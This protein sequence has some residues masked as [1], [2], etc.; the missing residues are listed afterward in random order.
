MDKMNWYSTEEKQNNPYWELN[1][2]PKVATSKRVIANVKL[3]YQIFEN[4]RFEIR[5]NIDY[6]DM[7]RDYRYA[8]D[9]NSVSVSS[10]GSWAY[11]KYTDQSVYTDGILTY[12]KNFGNF[13]LNALA[14][15]SYKKNIFNDGMNVSNGPTNPLQYPNFFTFANIP[16]NV[17][18]NQTINRTIKQ[19]GFVNATVGFKNFLFLDLAGRNDWASTLALTGNQSYF[20]PSVGASAIVSE[21]IKLPEVISF[22]KLRASFTQT[23]NEVPFNTVNPWNSIGGTG[24]VQTGVGTINYNTQQPFDN[25]KPEKIVANEYG[26]E[27]RFLNNR[28]GFDFT[29]YKDVS[30]NQFLT[31][32]APSGTAYTFYYVNAGKIVNRGFEFTVNIEPIRNTHFT[33]NTAFN[34]S[35]NKNKIVELISSDP[36]YQV[37]GDDEGF[38]SIIKA[39]GSFNDV[40][41]FKFARN[42]AGQIILAEGAQTSPAPTKTASQEY[43]GNVNPDFILGWNNNFT[44]NNFFA[45]ILVNGKFGGI[46]F[47]K[48]EA[49]LDS[50]GVSER[51]A[52]ARDLGYVPINAVLGATPVT[53]IDPATYYSTIGDRN[54]IMEPYIYSRT[55]VR[56]AQLVLGYTFRSKNPNP[57]FKDASVSLVGR[58]LFFLY[59]K[60]PYDPEQAMSTDNAMQ[61]NDIF[62]LPATRSFGLNVKF[63]F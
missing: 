24:N 49:F 25:L 28:L 36:G 62:S 30:T 40:Y 37:G 39:G 21:M 2:D 54:K 16:N 60:A 61:S 22:L 27:I 11:T 44:F 15:L 1:K 26:A 53:T 58:N 9:G 63:T 57:L 55:N 17:M 13:S 50:Y 4:L 59:K 19:G 23:A 18:F 41:V 12:N 42:K 34:G 8:A 51:T 6:N 47:S 33:W 38:A 32:R 43:A 52:R 45:N 46:A 14:G 10:N 29:L 3:S 31:L 20:Y 56:L 48:T 35:Q 7:L 5:G